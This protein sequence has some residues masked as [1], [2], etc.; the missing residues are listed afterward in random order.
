MYHTLPIFHDF[1]IQITFG[2]EYIPQSFFLCKLIHCVVTSSLSGPNI[3]L[4]NLFLK[5]PFFAPSSVCDTKFHNK[6]KD[7]QNYSSF[8]LYLHI[9][10]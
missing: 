2:G 5:N 3:F 9:F 6:A 1:I 10:V 8:Y 4:N 7:W